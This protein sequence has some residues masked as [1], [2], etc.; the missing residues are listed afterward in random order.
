M[1]SL[2]RLLVVAITT[3]LLM[4]PA[5]A[6]GHAIVISTTPAT[7]AVIKTAPT[8]VSITFN[9]NINGIGARVQVIGADGKH[10]EA[11]SPTVAG[12]VLSAALAT[13]LPQGTA[14]VAWSVISG[15]GHRVNSAFLFSVGHESTG[16]AAAAASAAAAATDARPAAATTISALSR[17]LRF[18]GIVLL[19]G[20]LLVIAFVWDPTLRRGR[21]E[22]PTTADA[23]DAAF[24]PIAVLLARLAPPLLAAIAV[25][26][27]PIDAWSDGITT[28]GALDLRQGQ[29]A[30][31]QAVLALVA[32]PLIVRVARGG[33]QRIVIAALIPVLLL[34]LTPGLSGHASAQSTPW[35]SIAIDWVH[36]LAAGAWGGSVLV[37]AATAPAVYRATTAET[38]GPLVRGLV[39]RFTRVALLALAALVATGVLATL[40]LTNTFSDVWTTSWGRVL[41]AKVVVVVLAV[42]TAGIVRRGSRRFSNA[43]QLE[44]L[45]IVVAIALTGTL[46]GLAPQAPTVAAAA[47]ANM[48]FHLTQKIDAREAQVDITPGRARQANEVHVIV[49]NG[50]GQPA[51]DVKDA[52]VVLSRDADTTL[53]VPLT[54]IETAHWTGSIRIP[55]AGT[56]T[57]VVRLRIGDFREESFHGVL[58]A[59]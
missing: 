33:S 44:A 36:V 49:T 38:R 6:L 3:A 45:L 26:A 17:A 51:L 21:T 40:M 47:A 58:T 42:L 35:L 19:L 16:G 12:H 52:S 54:Q 39:S 30:V 23:A 14:T 1:V 5:N 20:L 29:I 53:H 2:R 22:D 57:V 41:I 43:V 13:G 28:R 25:I 7:N 59:S 11:G 27:I 32:W 4:V 31:A 55:T 46:T 50:V 15:D 24:R 8:A 10:Y 9:E 56:W 37:L 48:P 34:A 18:A